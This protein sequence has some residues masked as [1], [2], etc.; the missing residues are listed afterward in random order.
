MLAKLL[1]VFLVLFL[2][3]CMSLGGNDKTEE[4]K[5][6][7]AFIDKQINYYSDKTVSS[8]DIPPDLTTPSSQKAFKLSQYVS[9]APEKVID[10][11]GEVKEKQKEVLNILKEPSNIQVKKSGNRRWLVVEKKPDAI[12]GLSKSFLKSN[13]FS[14]KKVNKKIGLIET[15]FLEN[16]AEIP[17][18]NLGM[19]RSFLGSKFGA[20]VLPTI[21]KYRIRL[22]PINSGNKTAV[23]LSL[24]SMAEVAINSGSKDENTIWQAQPK[25]PTLEIAMLYKLMVYLGG[26]HAQ[27]R[28]KIVKVKDQEKITVSLTKGVGGY[29]KLVFPT[30]QYDTWDNMGWAL[31]QLD[32]DVKDKDVKEGSFYIDV[33]RTQDIGWFSRIFGDSAIKKSFQILVKQTS[34]NTTEV[35]FNDIS[36]ENEQKTIDFSH[37]FLGNIAKQF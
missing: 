16:H 18:E 22:E 28:E 30:N 5:Q 17:K 24:S 12:W 21:D 32:I 2:S 8:L 23:Y 14:I 20:Y 3:G 9:N 7:E 29:A 26:D 37:E 25:D 36:E 15:D 34:S 11:S 13:G 33:A 27:A 10:F 4:E 31:D 6:R 1:S 35:Y 19:I